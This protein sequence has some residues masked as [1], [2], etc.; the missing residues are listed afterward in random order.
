MLRRSLAHI[1]VPLA[2]VF[3]VPSSHAQESELPIQVN[4]PGVVEA[5]WI[6]VIDPLGRRS[7]QGPV[8]YLAS[9]TDLR[10]A[11]AVLTVDGAFRRAVA[12]RDVAGADRI[13][14]GQ[15]A[16]VEQSGTIADKRTMLERLPALEIQGLELNRVTVRFAENIA[17]V[18]GSETQITPATREELLFTRTYVLTAGEWRLL[19]NTQFR[20]PRQ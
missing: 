20:D 9:N 3:V 5:K 13:L 19:S 14:S 15:F 6:T 17:T 11:E 16:G 8:F 10:R 2:A 12:N 18:T 1:V 4:V 7:R